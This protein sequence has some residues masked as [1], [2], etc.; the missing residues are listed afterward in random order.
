MNGLECFQQ[1]SR[2]KEQPGTRTVDRQDVALGRPLLC[3][4]CRHP[5]TTRAA[6]IEV[7]GSHEHVRSNPHGYE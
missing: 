1:G 5:I 6:R 4:R 7:A 2:P 3:A